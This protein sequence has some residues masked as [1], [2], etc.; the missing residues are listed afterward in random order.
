MDAQ[1][2]LLQARPAGPDHEPE[3][4]RGAAAAEAS[5]RWQ[6][7]DRTRALGRQGVARAR[8]ALATARRHHLEDAA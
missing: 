6:L 1:L 4:D 7:D 2:H 3:A 8:E 5:A